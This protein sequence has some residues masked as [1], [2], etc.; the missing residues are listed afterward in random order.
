MY[1]YPLAVE[2]PLVLQS[3][4]FGLCIFTRKVSPGPEKEPHV[5]MILNLR[6]YTSPVLKLVLPQKQFSML[7]PSIDSIQGLGLLIAGSGMRGLRTSIG[8]AWDLRVWGM[9]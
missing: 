8:V 2:L 1:F 9:G 7:G 4:S 6:S 3:V 5:P